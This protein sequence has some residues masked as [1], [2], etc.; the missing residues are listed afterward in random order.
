MHVWG[1]VDH[2]WLML[3]RDGSSALIFV[4]Q[5][6]I[7]LRDVIQNCILSEPVSQC[8]PYQQYLKV[9][10]CC[11]SSLFQ[12]IQGWLLNRWHGKLAHY[13]ARTSQFTTENMSN[14][15][16]KYGLDV[17]GGLMTT[18]YSFQC[19]AVYLNYERFL[20]GV[21]G[22]WEKY[23][24]CGIP[25]AT[26]HSYFLRSIAL[27]LISG[28]YSTKLFFSSCHAVWLKY[29][30]RYTLLSKALCNTS[31]TMRYKHLQSLKFFLNS[32]ISSNC[33]RWKT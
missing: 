26:L 24:W 19:I 29:C 25:T 6:V 15:W 10:W 31:L 17:K 16:E 12:I 8:T 20:Q 7:S 14:R 2:C 9:F 21:I 30:P 1:Q 11:G 32:P 33:F 23:T 5:Q 22:L 13:W 27:S 4:L 28:W 3:F 18:D